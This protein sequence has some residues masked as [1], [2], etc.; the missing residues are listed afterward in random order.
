MMMRRPNAQPPKQSQDVRIACSSI[1]STAL[2]STNAVIEF[3]HDLHLLPRMAIPA[4]HPD[5][6]VIAAARLK[7]CGANLLSHLGCTMCPGLACTWEPHLHGGRACTGAN[8][9]PNTIARLITPHQPDTGCQAQSRRAHQ[10]YA[11]M[12]MTTPQ[13]LAAEQIRGS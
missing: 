6:I 13:A 1:Q 12:P 9:M 7:G 8:E 3:L 2:G 5:E 4:A 10:A 11:A